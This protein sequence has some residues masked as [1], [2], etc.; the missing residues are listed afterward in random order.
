MKPAFVQLLGMATATTL[1]WI[2][3]AIRGQDYLEDTYAEVADNAVVQ[4]PAGLEGLARAPSPSAAVE[5]Y[6]KA[7]LANPNNLLV[8][9]VY[10]RRM[11]ELGAP[12]MCASQA[13]RITRSVPDDYLAW[14]VLA[15]N[16]AA[17]NDFANALTQLARA[18]RNESRDPFVQRTGGQLMAWFD[19]AADQ[20]QLPA[21]AIDAARDIRRLLG[22]RSDFAAAY[23]DARAYYQQQGQPQGPQGEM[24]AE[25]EPAPGTTP[26]PAPIEPAPAPNVGYDPGYVTYG[27]DYGY[28]YPVYGGTYVG[29][30]WYSGAYWWPWCGSST[31]IVSGN[32]CWPRYYDRDHRV[33]SWGRHNGYDNDRR[34]GGQRWGS[35]LYGRGNAGRSDSHA[36]PRRDAGGVSHR[37]PRTGATLRGG[38]GALRPSTSGA[39]HPLWAD[40]P[41]AKRSTGPGL[42]PPS[43]PGFKPPS[44]PGLKPPG[45]PGLK[46]PRGPAMRAPSSRG[47]RAPA[48]LHRSSAAPRPSI[49]QAPRPISRRAAAPG[50]RAAPRAAPRAGFGQVG[51]RLRR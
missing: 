25:P 39:R 42:K 22:G 1:V 26:Q 38:Q 19:T 9:Q 2:V 27:Y 44:N 30:P 14:A 21:D 35:S 28:S 51:G 47:L 8:D 17:N 16:S 7:R 11:V 41:G 34:W 45:N 15:F 3:P 18:A 46:V 31:I 4:A 43:S 48:S 20:A 29:Y 5:A 40:T 6:A 37:G 50:P 10:M 24:S 36:G 49:G 32:R 13:E 12:E 33:Y 23:R